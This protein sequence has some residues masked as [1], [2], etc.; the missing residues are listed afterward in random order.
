MRSLTIDK[1]IKKNSNFIS[2]KSNLRLHR[3]VNGQNLITE[4]LGIFIQDPNRYC[5]S[6][7][8]QTLISLILK[9]YNKKKLS[10]KNQEI[11]LYRIFLFSRFLLPI[12]TLAEIL[13]S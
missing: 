3:L 10:N 8:L 5:T 9:Y 6:S 7:K 12:L 13:S 2:R 1:F 4:Q 11:I